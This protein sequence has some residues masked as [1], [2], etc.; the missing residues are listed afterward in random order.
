MRTLTPES[1]L[2]FDDI[3]VGDQ[4]VFDVAITSDFV[5]QFS[6]LSG[7]YNPLH[8]DQAFAA[9]TKFKRRIAHGM[10]AGVLFSRLIGMYVPG[11]RGYYL[12]QNLAFRKPIEIDSLVTVCGR[13]LQKS[14]AL[15]TLTISTQL[16]ESRSKEIL[17][18]GTAVVQMF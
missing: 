11:G 4:F 3:A 10:T 12:S 8:L 18:D 9:N 6:S 15:K 5:R 14:G 1:N 2:S 17:V 16:Q 7:D 13:V